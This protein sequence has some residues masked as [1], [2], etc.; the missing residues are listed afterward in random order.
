MIHFQNRSVSKGLAAPL[1]RKLFLVSINASG[2]YLS[3]PLVKYHIK[4]EENLGIGI[5]HLPDCC[6]GHS[7]LQPAAVGGQKVPGVEEVAHVGHQWAVLGRHALR[8]SESNLI[9]QYFIN[10]CPGF[11][12]ELT[13]N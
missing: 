9:C 10:N 7:E 5:V 13:P 12:M 6:H 3:P 4:K 1:P 2:N 11:A 8:T